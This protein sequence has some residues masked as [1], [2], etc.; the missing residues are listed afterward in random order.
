MKR[1]HDAL[2][3]SSLL[4]C[5]IVLL[6]TGQAHAGEYPFTQEVELTNSDVLTQGEPHWTDLDADDDADVVLVSAGMLRWME[7]TGD[8]SEAFDEHVLEPEIEIVSA[9]VGDLD[10]DGDTDV[11]AV[12]DQLRWYESIENGQAFVSHVIDENSEAIDVDLGDIDGD[13]DL[14]IAVADYA[15]GEPGWY[16]NPG[17]PSADWNSMRVIPSAL[18]YTDTIALGDFDGDGDADLLASDGYSGYFSHLVFA[19]GPWEETPLDGTREISSLSVVDIDDDGDLDVLSGG[20][21]TAILMRNVAGGVFGTEMLR[22]TEWSGVS[23]NLDAGDVDADGDLD[24]VAVNY[25]GTPAVSWFD[26]RDG[27]FDEEHVISESFTGGGMSVADADCDGDADIVTHGD[28]GGWSFTIFVNETRQ[29]ECEGGSDSGGNDS[30]GNDD[31]G[32]D[33]GGNDDGD[34]DSAGDESGGDDGGGTGGSEGGEEGGDTDGGLGEQADDAL[35]GLC[36]VSRGSGV[37][38]SGLA[39]LLLGALGV[40]RRRR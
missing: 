35:G 14:D 9:I 4:T 2:A 23:F 39:L 33:S 6:A 17:D 34:D 26:N 27:E 37:P 30:G 7:N 1:H 36:S 25:N 11:V 40:R 18:V 8:P 16:E 5:A 21:T 15:T 29:G 31:G 3:L 12:G 38:V 22:D 32:N 20:S 24:I 19:D 13:G 28:A 10:G